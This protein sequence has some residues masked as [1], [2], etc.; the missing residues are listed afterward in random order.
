MA[1]LLTKEKGYGSREGGESKYLE[2]KNWNLV[3]DMIG[4]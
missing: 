4:W 3:L 1:K 2:Y